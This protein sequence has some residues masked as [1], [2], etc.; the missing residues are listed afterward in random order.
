M[1]S[2]GVPE[3][4]YILRPAAKVVHVMLHLTHRGTPLEQLVDLPVGRE[5]FIVEPTVANRG[6]DDHATG[7]KRL[8]ITHYRRADSLQ[9]YDGVRAHPGSVVKRAWHAKHQDVGLFSLQPDLHPIGRRGPTRFLHL[10][11]VAGKHT[12]LPRSTVE[13]SVDG[14]EGSFHRLFDLLAYLSELPAEVAV[15]GGGY[16]IRTV[17]GAGGM[18]AADRTPGGKAR[19]G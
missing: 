2:E 4:P 6:T 17:Q 18:V 3:L 19:G 1:I 15:S 10:S 13:D 9:H 7:F 11:G 5:P 16:E 14:E 8:G 12:K